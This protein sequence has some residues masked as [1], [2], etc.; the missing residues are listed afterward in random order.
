[1]G[2]DQEIRFMQMKKDL[3][4]TC[5][6]E[7][8]DFLYHLPSVEDPIYL[9]K[10]YALQGFVYTLAKERGIPSREAF[11]GAYVRLY[12]KDIRQFYE[13]TKN[14][15]KMQEQIHNWLGREEPYYEWDQEQDQ[16]LCHKVIGQIAFGDIA[17][18]F[19]SDW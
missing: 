3:P 2:L 8:S 1:M 16:A 9:R 12:P 19:Y 14:P 10:N 17:A 5:Q 18:Y 13:L 11:Y 7:R 6:D 4:D 15:K